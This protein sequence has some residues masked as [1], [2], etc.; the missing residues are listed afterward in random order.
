[1]CLG[2]TVL[3]LNHRSAWKSNSPKSAQSRSNTYGRAWLKKALVEN[4]YPDFLIMPV[5]NCTPLWRTWC[6]GPGEAMFSKVR[7]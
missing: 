4:Y 5:G 3:A 6:I 2:D 7:H 1:V